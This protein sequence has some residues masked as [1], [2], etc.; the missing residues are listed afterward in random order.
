MR[1]ERIGLLGV[2]SGMVLGGLVAGPGC[3]GSDDTVSGGDQEGLSGGF[4]Y[5]HRHRVRDAGSVGGSP[6]GSVDGGTQPGTGGTIG[7]GTGGTTGSGP[8]GGGVAEDCGICTEAQQCCDVVE[9]DGPGCSFNAATCSSMAGDAR[10]AYVNSC[11]T[12][13]VAVKD[14][15]A[16]H[17]P[18]GCP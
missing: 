5:H 11:L 1:L 18:A 3:G 16:G 2:I 15:W 17:P 12:F 10:P 6:V 14:A 13:V 4:L 9:V 7:G 8:V